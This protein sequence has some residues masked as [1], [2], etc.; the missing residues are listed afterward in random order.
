MYIKY[1]RDTVKTYYRRTFNLYIKP[2]FINFLLTYRCNSRCIMCNIWDT[3]NLNPD[4]RKE[5][6][7]AGEIE[8]FI[9][10]NLDDLSEVRNFG[11]SG[12]DPLLMRDDFVRIVRIIKDHLPRVRIGVQTNGLL[13]DLAYARLKEVLAF[14]PDFSIAVSIDAIGETH[15]KIRGVPQAFEKARETIKLAQKLGIK[16]I[17]AG[18]TL[19]RYN[20]KEIKKVKDY[21]ESLGVEFSCFLPEVSGYFQNV[22]VKDFQLTDEELYDVAKELKDCCGYHYYM[23]NLRLQIEGKRKRRLPCFS[24]FTSL[25]IDPYGNVK[26]CVLTVSGIEDSIF[27]NIR[28]QPLKAMLTSTHAANIRKKIKKCSCWCQCEVSSSV[29]SYPFDILQWLI[30]YCRHRKEFL[31]H[32]QQK[33]ERLS[34]LL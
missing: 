32:I 23:D 13:P 19:N 5:E 14:N 7:S 30:F 11:L 12:G 4:A 21:V 20:Y 24:G 10:D 34:T 6:L 33:K 29:I 31:R 15:D 8:K 3:Y 17:T 2:R 9:V 16:S 22:G 27:G 1:I 28:N 18:M 25:V 26:P